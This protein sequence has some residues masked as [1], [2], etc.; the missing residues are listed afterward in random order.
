MVKVSVLMPVYNLEDYI[1]HAME[2]LFN[3]TLK[4]I[5]IVCVNDGSVDG[6]LKIL[7]EFESKYDFIKVYSQENKGAGPALNK[8]IEEATGEYIAFLDADDIYVDDDALEK[9]Y[10]YAVENDA[11]MV[12]GNLKF[13]EGANY[14]VV[15]ADHYKRKL[16]RLCETKSSMAPNQYGIPYAFYKNIFKRE[17]LN[18]HNIRFPPYKR[19]VDTLFLARVLVN[20]DRIYTIPVW[21]YGYNHAVG[22]GFNKKLSD[23]DFIRNFFKVFKGVFDVFYEAGF[24]DVAFE[25][26]KELFLYLKYEDNATD[27]GIYELVME[28]F[29]DDEYYFQDF[30]N[31]YNVFV[32]TQL[33]H[34]VYENP[35]NELLNETKGKVSKL[36][37]PFNRKASADLL[38]K[39]V[40]LQTSDDV[41]EF[42]H[43]YLE[44]NYLSLE[45]KYDKLVKKNNK[46]KKKNTK[47]KK[48]LK[49]EKKLTKMYSNSSSWKI[50]APLRAIKRIFR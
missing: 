13:V 49:K 22:G 32:A 41:D 1:E 12:A 34:H 47:L 23:Y 9:M 35:T 39:A 40:V 18:K 20:V 16:Y 46:L 21:L 15:D 29:G 48:D 2:S 6:S 26:K 31:G 44:V 43:R 36:E 50:T 42:T 19:G 3:Q 14:K 8:C 17:F 25:F 4:D 45:K 5:E 11:D 27:W 24:D 38:R 30:R 7:R 37:L 33:I 10:D 28:V